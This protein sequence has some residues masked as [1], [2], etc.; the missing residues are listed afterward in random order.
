MSR[1]RPCPLMGQ[2]VNHLPIN[3]APLRQKNQVWSAVTLSSGSGGVYA[4]FSLNA[5]FS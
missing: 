2:T 5:G 4:A 1:H 3:I